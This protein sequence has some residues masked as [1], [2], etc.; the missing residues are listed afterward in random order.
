MAATEKIL[1]ERHKCDVAAEQF[2]L[3]GIRYIA[4]LDEFIEAGKAGHDREI[5]S[6]RERVRVM[7]TFLH[8]LFPDE[9]ADT[10]SGAE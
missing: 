10:T 2:Y 4:A 8:R 7:E 6:P 9:F 1:A 5:V 3:A